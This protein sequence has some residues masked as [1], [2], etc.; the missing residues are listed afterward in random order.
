MPEDEEYPP[1]LSR[2]GLLPSDL[3]LMIM[4][5]L[6]D[7]QTLCNLVKAYPS[8]RPTL[9]ARFNT[10]MTLVLQNSSNGELP[11]YLRTIISARTAG[12]LRKKELLG[13]LR[14]HFHF[15]ESK[16][17]HLPRITT[18]EETLDYVGNLLDAV[19]FFVHFCV[20]MFSKTW[21]PPV[22]KLLPT[23]QRSE[24]RIRRALLR[25]KL[26]WELLYQVEHPRG[27]PLRNG[28]KLQAQKCY[29]HQFEWWELEECACIYD[30]FSSCLRRAKF[31]TLK[32]KQ[33]FS[34]KTEETLSQ[35]DYTLLDEG[36]PQLH[37]FI[38]DDSEIRCDLGFGSQ[39]YEDTFKVKYAAGMEDN[40]DRDI[41]PGD[42]A[43]KPIRQRWKPSPP[44]G[45]SLSNY[46][47][48]VI[49]AFNKLQRSGSCPDMV[50]VKA[51]LRRQ[52]WCFWEH[53][54]LELLIRSTTPFENR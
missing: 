2:F 5:R 43:L 7:V 45:Y 6:R 18:P 1:E 8:I 21:P 51:R 41:N 48:R 34:S 31:R 14:T 42:P 12:P 36:L 11:Q 20:R 37:Y 33:K 22:L 49:W 16:T 15:G 30:L 40:S 47:Y 3:H 29:W 44:P 32:I 4:E 19:E 17:C 52:G 26:Y 50:V 39:F 27:K 9:I 10:V 28:L 35:D 23:C 13:F 24:R 25:L 53:D 46:T 54:I 38:N